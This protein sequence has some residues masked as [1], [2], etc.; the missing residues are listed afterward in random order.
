MSDKMARAIEDFGGK[1]TVKQISERMEWPYSE[2]VKH[3]E[4]KR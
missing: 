2:C 4:T 1:V 3:F